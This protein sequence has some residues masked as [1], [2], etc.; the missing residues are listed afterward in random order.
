MR[1]TT[2]EPDRGVYQLPRVIV[3]CP[4]DSEIRRREAIDDMALVHHNKPFAH[5]GHNGE[6][7]A[8][9]DVSEPAPAAK[10]LQ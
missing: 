8:H 4:L 5:V 10:V 7:V 6:V 9:Q 3:L 2:P 1:S